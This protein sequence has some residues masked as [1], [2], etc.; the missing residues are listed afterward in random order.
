VPDKRRY[1]GRDAAA[2][3]AMLDL[4]RV[5]LRERV[6][7]TL[8]V[9]HALGG[10]GASAGTLVLAEEQ[11]AGRGRGGRAWRS[12]HG[13]GIWL[14]LLER[15]ADADAIE[16]LSIR[17]GLRAAAALDRYAAERVALKWPNDLY[18]GARKLGGV[19]IEARWRD[20]R[21]EWVAIGVGLNVRVPEGVTEAASLE[22]GTDRGALLAELIP[23][24]RAAAAARGPLS[25]AE[26]SRYATRDLAAGRACIE[27][28]RGIVRGIDARGRL[29]V[30]RRGDVVAVGSGSLRLAD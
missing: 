26:L 24:L 13:A 29:L 23:A 10:S 15:P 19:L 18:V 21:P 3:A 8:D 1:E 30:E 6:T 5:E 22:P 27:P 12:E 7:S 25:D 4:P 2:L 9:A 11:T 14:T 28:V 17:V 20:E 16:L